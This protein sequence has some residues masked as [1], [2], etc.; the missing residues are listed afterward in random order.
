M[1]IGVDDLADT[2]QTASSHVVR[3]VNDFPVELLEL[4]LTEVKRSAQKDCDKSF[5]NA[6]TTCS[7]WRDIG[8]NLLWTDVA[9][10][11][12]SLPKFC[13][14]GSAAVNMIRSFTLTMDLSSG[15]EKGPSPN[16][17]EGT[18]AM[19]R[20]YLMISRVSQL[21]SLSIRV[22]PNVGGGSFP[23]P[24][25]RIKA[26]IDAAPA[27][28]RHFELDTD[29]F[30]RTETD[31]AH[32]ICPSISGLLPQLQD[33]RL[34]VGWLC[35]ESFQCVESKAPVVKGQGSLVVNTVGRCGSST[36]RCGTDLSHPH[37][38]DRSASSIL[39]VARHLRTA[40]EVATS[41]INT[42]AF[43]QYVIIS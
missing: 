9:V 23:V 13:A 18:V 5:T 6:L 7:L 43:R 30:W 2:M 39:D 42:Q 40:L 38:Q 1:N 15:G 14:S 27:S 3:T 16:I 32:H 28:L 8:E 20:L 26:L 21:E 10:T 4:V 11:F 22:V 35:E 25:S 24:A 12:C 34:R 37:F 17:Y 29:C 31:D 36:F 19:R 41:K 33:L